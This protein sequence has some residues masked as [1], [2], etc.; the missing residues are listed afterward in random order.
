MSSSIPATRRICGGSSPFVRPQPIG[1]GDAERDKVVAGG[2]GLGERTGE[3]LPPSAPAAH[4]LAVWEAEMTPARR[5]PPRCEAGDERGDLGEQVAGAQEG[6]PRGR[7]AGR[8]LPAARRCCAN[9]GQGERSE[10]SGGV[11]L[12]G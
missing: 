10:G 8:P 2:G 9:V 3:Q 12:R 7:A 6:G 4:P 11:G 1:G 5:G